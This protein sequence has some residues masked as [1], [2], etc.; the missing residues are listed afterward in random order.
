MVLEKELHHLVSPTADTEQERR[1]ALVVLVFHHLKAASIRFGSSNK[2]ETALHKK[3]ATGSYRLSVFFAKLFPALT[4][5]KVDDG[6][7]ALQA[8]LV[9]WSPAIAVL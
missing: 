3:T 7:V 4:E 9:Q 1:R 8:G 5:Q 6:L 2:A